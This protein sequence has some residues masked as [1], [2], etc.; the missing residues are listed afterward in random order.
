MYQAYHKVF[1]GLTK[2]LLMVW[3]KPFEPMSIGLYYKKLT[4]G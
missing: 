3:P 1:R 2:G 4:N